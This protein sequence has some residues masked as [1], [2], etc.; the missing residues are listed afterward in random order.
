MLQGPPGPPG[1]QGPVGAPG[2]A[3]SSLFRA[4]HNIPITLL[5][6]SEKRMVICA[7][8]SGRDFKSLLTAVSLH[9][10]VYYKQVC[11]S[12]TWFAAGHNL[13]ELLKMKLCK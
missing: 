12:I 1:L 6:S 9:S 5:R 10:V 8:C 13:K 2:I 4:N 7:P 11:I 3:V